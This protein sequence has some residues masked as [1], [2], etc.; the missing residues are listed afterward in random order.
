[1]NVRDVAAL[2]GVSVGTVS[3][4]LNHREKVSAATWSR[5]ARAIEELGF[6]RNDA[7]RQLRAGRSRTIGLVVPDIRNPF[8]SELGR[9]AELRASE[10][11]LS[12]ILANSDQ[13]VDKETAYLD[14]FEQ[15][16][17]YGV[18][19]SPVGDA[20]SRLKTLRARGISTVLVD[21]PSTDETLSS[22]SVDDAQGGFIAVDHLIS[23]GRRRIAFVGGGLDITQVSNR[24]RGAS[25][26]VSDHRGVT[27]ESIFAPA[28]TVPEGRRI[29]SEI[30]KRDRSDRPDAIFAANDLTAIGVFQGLTERDSDVRIP[31]DIALIGYDDIDFAAATAIP[32]SSIR[33]PSSLIGQTAIEIL[34]E[35]AANPDLAARHVVYPPELIARM[36]TTG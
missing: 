36:S 6:V 30:R 32:L 14:L 19:I 9:G 28:L 17:V 20:I 23:L 18:L 21:I 29:G 24:L 5:V 22:V 34:L 7:A 15:Q 3:N 31:G 26:A 12:V 27:L 16:R 11:D 33:Q 13:S 10:S 1:M 25:L 35:E 4:A 8:F 2:A